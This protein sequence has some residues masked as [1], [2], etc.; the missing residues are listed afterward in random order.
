[1]LQLAKGVKSVKVEETRKGGVSSL[2]FHI[3]VS[4]IKL[5]AQLAWHSQNDKTAGS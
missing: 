1:M 5:L 3:E 2:C 4:A